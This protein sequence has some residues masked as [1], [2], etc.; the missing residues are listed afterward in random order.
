[1]KMTSMLQQDHALS[2]S[3]LR[4]KESTCKKCAS[5][6]TQV[7]RMQ[8]ANQIGCGLASFLAV[9]LKSCFLD[10]DIAISTESRPN[11]GSTGSTESLRDQNGSQSGERLQGVCRRWI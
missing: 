3:N 1:M 2:F 6:H 4:S 7:W 11:S 8:A 10:P 9:V 5:S